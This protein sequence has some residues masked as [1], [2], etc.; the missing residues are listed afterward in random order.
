MF[1]ENVPFMMMIIKTTITN[2]ISPRA[3]LPVS[4]VQKSFVTIA[5]LKGR[6]V[7][8]D[9]SLQWVERSSEA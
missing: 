1:V 8:A 4:L 9:S 6:K 5:S 3:F 2:G 7:E